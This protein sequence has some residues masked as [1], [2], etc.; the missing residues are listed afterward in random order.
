MLFNSTEI[1]TYKEIADTTDIPTQEL[2]R[3]LQGLACV[4]V[5]YRG[6]SLCEGN[7][8]RSAT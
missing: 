8:P 3:S 7:T 4:K 2:K 1:L 5:G 6:V